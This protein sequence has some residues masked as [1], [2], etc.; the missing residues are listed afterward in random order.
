MSQV[1]VLIKSLINGPLREA[2]GDTKPIKSL[3]E[4]ISKTLE[5]RFGADDVGHAME[6]NVPHYCILVGSKIQALKFIPESKRK[7]IN[8]VNELIECK[9]GEE[10]RMSVQQEPAGKGKKQKMKA[11]PC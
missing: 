5:V 11:C 6:H 1:Y 7:I 4:T 2:D 10:T 8:D 3:K 9:H